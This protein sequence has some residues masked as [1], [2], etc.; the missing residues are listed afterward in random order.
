MTENP[1]Q[2][3]SPENRE[4]AHAERG[5]SGAARRLPPRRTQQPRRTRR[6]GWTG[7]RTTRPQPVYPQHQPSYGRPPAPETQQFGP[8]RSVPGAPGPA[9]QQPTPV[10]AAQHR[11]SPAG[12][13]QH[14]TPSTASPYSQPGRLWR[15]P[16]RL[17]VCVQPG[18]RPEAQGRLRC[19]DPR[20]Q[21]PRR[22][23]GRRRRGRR[24]PRSCWATAAITSTGSSN[25][26]QAG[27]GHREQQG[28][29]ER[30][31]R[32]CRQGHPQRRDHQGLQ[33]QRGRHGLRH[34]PRR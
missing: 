32:R 1:A 7:P 13:A 12:S 24:R 10:R 29:R 15:Q 25:S 16:A 14:G 2:G 31:H 30:H 17:A 21:H 27:P 8:R 20:G 26:S 4:P 6:S 18:P 33:R 9:R 22:R 5:R 19:P 23:P 34:H 11:G 28:R 3:A